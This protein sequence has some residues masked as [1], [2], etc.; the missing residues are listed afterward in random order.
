MLGI[1]DSP[2]LTAGCLETIQNYDGHPQNTYSLDSKYQWLLPLC[3][4]MIVFGILDNQLAFTAL[5]GNLRSCDCDIYFFSF[6]K[7]TFTSVFGRKQDSFCICLTI[8]VFSYHHNF[9]FNYSH[10]MRTT[11]MWTNVY[12]GPLDLFYPINVQ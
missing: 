9:R 1:S 12:L 6:W 11:S 8:V 10:K 7:P 3:S 5:C 4:H 2:R